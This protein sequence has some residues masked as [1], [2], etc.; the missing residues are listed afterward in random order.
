MTILSST[1]TNIGENDFDDI[2]EVPYDEIPKGHPTR[3]AMK[4]RGFRVDDKILVEVDIALFV[5]ESKY[6]F[7]VEI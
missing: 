1:I 2:T 7:R 3:T 5:E 4:N 6:A